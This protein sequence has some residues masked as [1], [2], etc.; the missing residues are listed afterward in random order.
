MLQISFR[1]TECSLFI[2]IPNKINGSA[3]ASPFSNFNNAAVGF[4]DHFAAP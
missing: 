3:F 4:I 1:K 2:K